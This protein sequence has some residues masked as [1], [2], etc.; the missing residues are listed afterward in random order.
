MWII[1]Y[2]EKIIENPKEIKKVKKFF[3]YF[4]ALLVVGDVTLIALYLT[5][6]AALIHPYFPW[7]YVP[8]FSSLFGF[9]STYLIIVISK[10]IGHAFLMKPEDYYD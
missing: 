8:G 5:D 1:R 7:D 10:G 4:G 2:L 3:I 6:T 9:V